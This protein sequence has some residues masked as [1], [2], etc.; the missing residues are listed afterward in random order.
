MSFSIERSKRSVATRAGDWGLASISP[1]DVHIITPPL[2]NN[3]DIWHNTKALQF[4]NTDLNTNGSNIHPECSERRSSSVYSDQMLFGLGIFYDLMDDNMGERVRFPKANSFH[5][6]T[7]ISNILEQPTPINEK[8]LPPLPSEALSLTT[9]LEEEWEKLESLLEEGY[10]SNTRRS[11]WQSSRA[12]TPH[13]NKLRQ[14]HCW[15]PEKPKKQDFMS[16]NRAF[17]RAGIKPRRKHY[18]LPTDPTQNHLATLDKAFQRSLIRPRPLQ[19]YSSSFSQITESS[20]VEGESLTIPDTPPI[21]NAE[22]TAC[23]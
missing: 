22:D 9:R 13:H 4:Q 14:E 17:D 20:D 6:L 12:E 21:P 16:I 7:A 18:T 8:P 10:V 19:M 23:D 2:A 11:M 3:A 5:S 1:D 15:F